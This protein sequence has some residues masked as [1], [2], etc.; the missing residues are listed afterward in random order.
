MTRTTGAV[1][2]D[3]TPYEMLEIAANCIDHTADDL[4]NQ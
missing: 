4:F 1:D 2:D 3:G